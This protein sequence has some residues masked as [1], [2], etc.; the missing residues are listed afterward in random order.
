MAE[1]IEMEYCVLNLAADPHPRGVYPDI[2]RRAAKKWV[3]FHGNDSAQITAPEDQGVGIHTGRIL[4]WTDLD[5]NDPAIDKEKAEEVPLE[6]TEITVPIAFGINGRTFF[7][8]LREK[9]HKFFYEAK[10]EEGKQLS[11][12]Y[13]KK[14]LDKLFGG[15]RNTRVE[16]TVEPEDD[17]LD[18]ILAIPVLKTLEIHI[19][20]PNPDDNEADMAQVLKEMEAEN[21][22]QI[23]IKLRKKRGK[24]GIKPSKRR[25]AQARV[26]AS[27]GHVK[28]TGMTADKQPVILSTA[29]YPKRIARKID[30]HSVLATLLSVAR[31]TIVGKN[32]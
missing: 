12:Y 16:V 2:L 6:E 18:K 28:A 14:I 9:D 29:E 31:N 11:P 22:S 24:N 30:L 23:D 5:P 15:M 4:V 19:A 10:N 8:A 3:Q 21:V 25:L 1:E 20:P 17:A 7:Y 13:L 26:A 27:N 32:G